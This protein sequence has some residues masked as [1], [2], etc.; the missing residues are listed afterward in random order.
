MKCEFPSDAQTKI[1]P[2]YCKTREKIITLHL[3]QW[4]TRVSSKSH[5]FFGFILLLSIYKNLAFKAHILQLKEIIMNNINLTGE[6]CE[7]YD[8]N[9]KFKKI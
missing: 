2:A 1:R 6:T 4:D 8:H 3:I 7:I 5:A 9:D